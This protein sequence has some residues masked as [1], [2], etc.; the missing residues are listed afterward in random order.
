MKVISD[1]LSNQFL[2]I[3]LQHLRI[4]VFGVVGT[5]KERYV[6]LLSR[7][8]QGLPGRTMS[9]Q[10]GPVSALKLFPFGRI[11]AE[12]LTQ[13]V[14]RRHFFTPSR[15]GQRPLLHSAW[16]KTV[17]QESSAVFFRRWVVRSFD[18]D[19]CLAS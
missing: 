17:H 2:K 8:Q 7:V 9:G 10:L 19:H 18:A 5:I 16:P 14:A 3:G 4:I 1:F 15:H 6:T 13:L 11:V 12:P